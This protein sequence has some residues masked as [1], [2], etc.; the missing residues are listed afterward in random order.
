MNTGEKS[1]CQRRPPP[2]APQ[3]QLHYKE[4]KRKPHRIWLKVSVCWLGPVRCA[5][6]GLKIRRRPLWPGN[7]LAAPSPVRPASLIPNLG[8]KQH[9]NPDPGKIDFL[10]STPSKKRPSVATCQQG[11]SGFRK[12]ETPAPASTPYFSPLASLSCLLQSEGRYPE[13]LLHQF[14]LILARCSPTSI[15]PAKY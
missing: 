2:K 12:L 4:S 5:L 8:C 1:S 7:P 13:E 6:F 15:G 10:Q 9:R 3:N 11:K 14:V